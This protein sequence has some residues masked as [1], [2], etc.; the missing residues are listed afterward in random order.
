MVLICCYFLIFVLVISLFTG[1]KESPIRMNLIA[2][3]TLFLF[4]ARLLPM[5]SN[6]LFQKNYFLDGVW[7]IAIYPCILLSLFGGRGI[8]FRFRIGKKD[9][10][11]IAKW[12]ILLFAMI[13]P[14]AVSIGFA[15]PGLTTLH[16]LSYG[17]FFRIFFGVLFAAALPEEFF[18]R[19]YILRAMESH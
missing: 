1:Q 3:I 10:A 4:E 13:V 15:N 8:P 6:L 7:F 18:F 5:S 11:E 9:Y 16:S 2:M 14:I 17:K 12:F 19:G